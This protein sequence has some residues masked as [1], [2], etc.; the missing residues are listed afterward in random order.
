[1]KTRTIN[2]IKTVSAIAAV[3]SVAWFY[4]SPSYEPAITFLGSIATFLSFNVK[5]PKPPIQIEPVVEKN[6]AEQAPANHSGMLVAAMETAY[7]SDRLE[8]IENLISSIQSISVREL[9]ELLNLLYISD[10]PA[11]LSIICGKIERPITH[12]HMKKI[13]E[14]LY[15][16]DRKEATKYLV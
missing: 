6:D 14:T 7:I 12:K 15:I 3:L 4:A 9:L 10:R 5:Q 8:I 13:L 16:S 1:M 2:T 11:A